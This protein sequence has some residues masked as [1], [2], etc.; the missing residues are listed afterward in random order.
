MS[1]INQ[2]LEVNL[3]NPGRVITNDLVRAIAA[4]S[5]FLGPNENFL[6][7]LRRLMYAA[8]LP[9]DEVGEFV[10]KNLEKEL[11]W[12]VNQLVPKLQAY[13]VKKL[14]AFFSL[15]LYNAMI[16]RGYVIDDYQCFEYSRVDNWIRTTPNMRLTLPFVALQREGFDDSENVKFGW[17][18]TTERGIIKRYPLFDRDFTLQRGFLKTYFR[19]L[20]KPSKLS[21]TTTQSEG[22]FVESKKY[23]GLLIYWFEQFMILIF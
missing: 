12:V 16:F 18:F 20:F 21:S 4:R 17:K 14:F 2:K 23:S 7:K 11:G 15:V 5:D 8:E 22:E 13:L 6:S 9:K 19:S 3:D 1:R 10:S